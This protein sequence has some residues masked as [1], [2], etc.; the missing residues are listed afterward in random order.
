M[1][2]HEETNPSNVL[3]Q[4]ARRPKNSVFRFTPFARGLPAGG[5][6]IYGSVGQSEF[7]LRKFGESYNRARFRPCGRNERHAVSAG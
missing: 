3:A 2:G 4:S 1:T 6:A 5:W 7:R